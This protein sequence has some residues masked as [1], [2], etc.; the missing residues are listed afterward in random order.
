[1]SN[2][3]I[4]WTNDDKVR[5]QCLTNLTTCPGLTV[6]AS[7]LPHENEEDHGE[8]ISTYSTYPFQ[9]LSMKR[10]MLLFHLG[11]RTILRRPL[12]RVFRVRVW[13]IAR[14]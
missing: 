7:Q 10:D 14:A 13:I 2:D 11:T 3:F 12:T 4:T 6:D 9:A 8:S 1:M 5:L